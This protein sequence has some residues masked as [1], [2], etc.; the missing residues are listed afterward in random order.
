MSNH[1]ESRSPLLEIIVVIMIIGV[2]GVVAMRNNAANKV[3]YNKKLTTYVNTNEDVLLTLNNTDMETLKIEL[4][5]YFKNECYKNAD[6][7]MICNIN[8]QKKYQNDYEISN[9]EFI[10]SSDK[11]SV[12]ANNKEVASNKYDDFILNINYVILVLNNKFQKKK[13]LEESWE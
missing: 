5:D 6:K 11:W 4:E 9:I 12:Y 2:M 3:E 8:R 1:T 13:N 7:I 10:K